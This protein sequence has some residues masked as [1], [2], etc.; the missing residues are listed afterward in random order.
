MNEKKKYNPLEDILQKVNGNFISLVDEEVKKNNK[1]LKAL[2]NEMI[3]KM[4]ESD[5]LFELLYEECFYGGSFYDGLKVSRPDE[6]DIHMLM[7]IPPVISK[8]ICNSDTPG[9]VYVECSNVEKLDDKYKVFKN[10]LTGEKNHMNALKIRQWMEGI[11]SKAMKKLSENNSGFLT[12]YKIKE[13]RIRKNGPA[14]TVKMELGK[15]TIDVDLVPCFIFEEKYWPGTPFRPN[16]IESKPNFSI[17]PKSPKHGQGDV[18]ELWLLNF[19]LQERELINDKAFLKPSIKL[20]KKL[21][22]KYDHKVIASYYIKNIALW[23]I[24]E[25]RKEKDFWTQSLSYMFMMVLQKYLDCLKQQ[26]IP[27][28]WNE[29]Y[30][31]ID[32]L[33]NSTIDPKTIVNIENVVK[34]MIDDIERNLENNPSVILKYLLTKEEMTRYTQEE[35]EEEETYYQQTLGQPQENQVRCVII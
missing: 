9:F 8:K 26:K 10:W 1:L 22:D 27:Y 30:N 15:N 16:P 3:Q 20:L 33:N 23:L 4:K 24:E 17:V 32:T 31:F 6:Y 14:F 12:K 21:R 19:Q 2:L 11:F 28:Y 29:A 18:S 13:Q 34:K 35:E 7:K 5:P 25:K